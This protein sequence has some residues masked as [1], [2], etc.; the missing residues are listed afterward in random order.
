MQTSPSYCGLYVIKDGQFVG[1]IYDTGAV[2]VVQPRPFTR[3]ASGELSALDAEAIEC[4]L[5]LLPGYE[6]VRR[7]KDGRRVGVRADESMI[8]EIP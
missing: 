6:Y 8:V 4:L 2:E 3:A 5:C 7:Y 1:F